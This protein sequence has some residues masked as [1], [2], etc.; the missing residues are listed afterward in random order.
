[1]IALSLLSAEILPEFEQTQ[2]FCNYILNLIA[3]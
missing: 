1:M 3:K 2:K